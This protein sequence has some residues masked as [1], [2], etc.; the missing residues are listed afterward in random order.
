[1]QPR[2]A[3]PGLGPEAPRDG[4]VAPLLSVLIVNFNGRQ[5]LD[6]CLASLARHLSCTYEVVVVDNASSDGSV[7][8][9]RRAH[10]G[11]RLV[12]NTRN[13]GFAAGNN[14]AAR[15]A[16]G[17]FL[18]LLNND[19]V[20]ASALDPMVELMQ[21]DASIGALGCALF[22]GDGRRQ[23]S[24]GREHTA[25]RLLLSWLPLQALSAGGWARRS[26]PAGSSTYRSACAGV[27]WVSGA[28]LLTRSGLW[29]QLGGLD[30]RYFM[31][32]EDADY[33][34]RVR[35]AGHRVAYSDCSRVVHFEGAGRP[36]R[37]RRAVLDTAR[38]YLT[39]GRKFYGP[40]GR[41]TLRTLLPAVFLLRAAAHR[42]VHALGRDPL[43][44]EKAGAFA[45][46]A[47]VLAGGHVVAGAS[48]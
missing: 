44:R 11:V 19:T 26:L 40:A 33:C 16:R 10:P 7:E 2:G 1:M 5:F 12:P 4:G 9:L 46:A 38:S 17:R 42:L 32:V 41:L 34:R 15:H 13:A 43:G 36:W 22:L 29:Q 47:L 8:H 25:W 48:S 21:A 6:E 14:L 28:C 37:G 27:E 30:E 20:V 3:A 39:Y 35:D 45:A 24:I 31:Y 18:L 23:E